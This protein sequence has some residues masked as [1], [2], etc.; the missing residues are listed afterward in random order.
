MKSTPYQ[1]A[2]NY[3]NNLRSSIDEE[4]AESFFNKEYI[5]YCCCFSIK[6]RACRGQELSDPDLID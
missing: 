5:G 2:Y 4:A 3:K 1:Y 6:T